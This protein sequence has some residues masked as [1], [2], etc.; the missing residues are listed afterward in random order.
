M[1]ERGLDA[2]NQEARQEYEA[3]MTPAERAEMAIA[4]EHLLER[5]PCDCQERYFRQVLKQA[6]E[7][8]RVR[9]CIA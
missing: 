5:S 4:E 6:A 9:Y 7:A 1:I 2:Q 3:Q 8:L